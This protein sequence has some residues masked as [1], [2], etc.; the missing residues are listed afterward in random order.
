MN[1]RGVWRIEG[2]RAEQ[3]PSDERVEHPR[4]KLAEVACNLT[5]PAE[6]DLRVTAPVGSSLSAV[7]PGGWPLWFY[8]DA[9]GARLDRRGVVLVSTAVDRMMSTVAFISLELSRPMLLLSA[10]ALP[11]LVLWWLSSLVDL[12]RWQR[13]LS[14]GVRGLLVLCLVLSLAGLNL[15]RSTQCQYV[16]VAIDRSASVGAESRQYADAYLQEFR[17]AVGRQSLAVL[18][19]SRQPGSVQPLAG[20]PSDLLDSA[21]PIKASPTVR[22]NRSERISRPHWNWPLP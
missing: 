22:T 16:V 4:V 6:S 5:D 3:R 17:Q 20:L 7:G 21:A 8:P 11:W 2:Q 13:V 18:E 14:L 19:F 9:G 12:P 1:Q 15:L 10:A